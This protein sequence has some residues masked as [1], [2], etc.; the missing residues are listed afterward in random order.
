LR[1]DVVRV[2]ARGQQCDASVDGMGIEMGIDMIA[3]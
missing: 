3:R 1:V 2:S